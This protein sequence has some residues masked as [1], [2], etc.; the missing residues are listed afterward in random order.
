MSRIGIVTM[1]AIA[2]LVLLPNR[3]T[4]QEK[5]LKPCASQGQTYSI[6][7]TRHHEARQS[8]TYFGPA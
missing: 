2:A 5:T 8:R 6:S 4:A 1:S 7:P 3:T